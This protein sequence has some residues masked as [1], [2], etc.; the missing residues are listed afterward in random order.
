MA[1]GVGWAPFTLEQSIPGDNFYRAEYASI[2]GDQVFIVV[3]PTYGRLSL[4]SSS[5]NRG[6]TLF[7]IDSNSYVYDRATYET[8]G[9]VPHSEPLANCET[10]SRSDGFSPFTDRSL[11]LTLCQSD[12]VQAVIYVI[13][14]GFVL[15]DGNTLR[16]SMA[17]DF[18]VAETIEAIQRA[19]GVRPAE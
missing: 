19:G 2:W 14:S 5:A 16:G 17:S 10:V 13:T 1:F 7:A 18:V 12:E 11:G 3:M 15:R 6:T 9:E 8:V 4:A